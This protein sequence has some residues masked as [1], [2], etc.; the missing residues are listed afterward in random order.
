MDAPILIVDGE[1][2]EADELASVL[3]HDGHRVEVERDAPGARRALAAEPA[4]GL[5]L[6]DLALP[7]LDAGA[8]LAELGRAPRRGLLPVI[9]I[10]PGGDSRA[11]VHALRAGA[12][13]AIARPFPPEEVAA[14]V[15]AL[16][17]LRDAHERLQIANEELT[18]C[19]VT[20]PLTGLFNRRYFEYRLAQ[21]LERS[22]RQDDPLALAILDLDHFK[23]VNDGYGHATGDAVLVAASRIFQQELRRVDVCTRW[24][25]EELAAILP[26]TDAD[27][28]RV[29]CQRVLRALRAHDGILAAPL[30]GGAREVVRFTA[31]AGVAVH[32]PGAGGTAEDLLRRADAALYLAKRQGRD[33][34]RVAPEAD[35]PPRP[36]AERCPRPAVA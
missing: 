29:V 26:S 33:R 10:A 3:A 14:R 24:G 9:A 23:R 32:A 36:T 4:P 6:L 17:R 30:A 12:D 18:R 19:S 11:R 8:V 16:L 7:E 27:G 28:A 20:D 31:S 1:C 22:R 34:L 5:V 21:E 13:D 15:A 25:G 2:A 35:V